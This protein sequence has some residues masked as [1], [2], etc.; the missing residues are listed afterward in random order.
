MMH[1]NLNAVSRST[2]RLL[3]ILGLIAG[4]VNGLNAD[5][6][7][8]RSV[9]TSGSVQLLSMERDY[10]NGVDGSSTSI[11]ATVN[12]DSNLS[13]NLSWHGQYVHVENLQEDGREDAAYWL[14]NDYTSLLN[15]LYLEYH[16]EGDSISEVSLKLGRQ[17][18]GYD[19]FPTYKTRHKGQ[20]FGGVSFHGKVLGSVSLDLGHIAD[21]SAWPSRVDGSSSLT[22]DFASISERLGQTGGDNG[23]QFIQAKWGQGESFSFSSYGYHV[24][25]Y[26]DTLGLKV[27]YL[28]HES[29]E[30]GA[31]NV[32]V[33][34]F[35]Q[36]GTRSG[37]FSSQDGRVVELNLNYKKN[38]LSMDLGWT[39]VGGDSTILN[40]FRTSF[41]IDATLLWYTNQFER[42]TDSA[43]LKTLYKHKQWTFYG[44]FIA[45]Q[46]QDDREETEANA[47]VK[48]Q[49]ENDIW[50][51][52]KG[53]YGTRD[54]EASPDQ[55]ARDLRLFVG[56]SF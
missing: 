11:S 38:A 40:P 25:G 52:F 19:F 29:E 46:H 5:D 9:Q 17:V 41:A 48:Y 10:G 18:A 2:V 7:F 44:A 36:E 20:A 56:R 49:F 32:S 31:Y 21:F 14:S 3:S 15:E 16:A 8:D 13:E 37:P 39:H 4:L 55:H 51:A 22:S 27:N 54:Y 6:H 24:D 47:V 50:V 28:L 35:Q 43:H 12:L 45:A 1:I 30:S 53:G 33:H 23:V 26:Y 34:A 42:G